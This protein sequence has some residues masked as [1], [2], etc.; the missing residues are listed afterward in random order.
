MDNHDS[1]DQCLLYTYNDLLLGEILDEYLQYPRK[2][3]YQFFAIQVS[4]AT[5]LVI[6]LPNLVTNYNFT[7]T[8]AFSIIT[9]ASSSAMFLTTNLVYVDCFKSKYE[10]AVTLSNLFRGMFALVIN[11]LSTLFD[12]HIKLYLLSVTMVTGLIFWMSSEFFSKSRELTEVDK[13]S[14]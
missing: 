6:L 5:T 11:P 10:T 1:D 7:I 9:G 2:S 8:V 4:V 13:E 12:F 14:E 3:I